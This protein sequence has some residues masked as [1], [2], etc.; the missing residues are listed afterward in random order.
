MIQLKNIKKSYGELNVLN[1]INLEINDGKE[2]G[3]AHV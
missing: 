3:R 1:D 2:I